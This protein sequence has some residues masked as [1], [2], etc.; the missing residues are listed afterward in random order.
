MRSRTDWRGEYLDGRTARAQP[1]DLRLMATGIEIHVEGGSTA[2]WPYAEIRQTQ[3]RYAG[4]EVRLERGGELSEALIVRDRDFLAS[5]R[6][7]GGKWSGR[8]YEP[9][10]RRLRIGLTAGAALSAIALAGALYLW[11]IP[12]FARVV[13]A[14]VPV[15][16]EEGLGASVVREVSPPAE[17]CGDPARLQRIETVVSRLAAGLPQPPAYRFRVFVDRRGMVNA[18]AAPGGFIVV[19]RGLLERTE[20]AEELAGVLAH[21]MQ[22][23]V[24]R[25]T[26]RMVVQHASTGLLVAAITGDV[27]GV[28]AYGLESARVLGALQYGRLAEE[29][30]DREGMRLMLAARIDP[31]GMISFFEKLESERERGPAVLKYLSSHPRLE[32]RI[33]RLKAIVAERGRPAPV[34]LFEDYDWADIRR[35]CPPATQP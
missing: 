21:E 26:T 33:A 13:A 29:E 1:A 7:V 31:A 22:H 35:I 5:L 16:W 11:G 34:K 10:R 6:A 18:L 30:A 19:F 25:H 27:T 15:A 14:W 28:M 17:R 24:Q 8:L 3:G 12:L 4:E 2:F 32:D 20:S 9:E 23:V